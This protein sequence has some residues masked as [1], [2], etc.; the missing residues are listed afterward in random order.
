MNQEKLFEAIGQLEDSLLAGAEDMGRR[1]RR[2]GWKVMLVA[3][4][5][6]GLAVTAAASPVI[7]NAL[8]GGKVESDDTLWLTPT[9]PVDGSSFEVAEHYITLEVELDA[10][11]PKTVETF[12]LPK[13]PEG[14]EQLAGHI[15][16]DPIRS[17]TQ[18]WWISKGTGEDIHFMQKAGGSIRKEDLQESVSTLYGTVPKAQMRTFAGVEG[19][20]IDV[21][22][23]GDGL[24]GDR[25]FFW[26]DGQYL[27][28][29]EM[30]YE[31][32]DAQLEV[33]VASVQPV[34]DITP[35]LVTM[36]QQELEAALG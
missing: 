5:V 3:A 33:M 14:M 4:V 6:A 31:Y 25:I 32:S 8:L 28:R 13:I 17:V 18:F 11:A 26:S 29:L 12:H 34:E 22:P 16:G 23:V 9:D 36:G 2:M 21:K 7:R 19:Y 24:N 27:F 10:D 15:L 1:H 35:Y 30:P 20:L